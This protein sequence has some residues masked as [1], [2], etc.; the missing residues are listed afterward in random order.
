MFS[1]MDFV[2]GRGGGESGCLRTEN[3]NWPERGLGPPLFPFPVVIRP[4]VRA[5][6]LTTRERIDIDAYVST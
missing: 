2:E 4:I 1:H 3:G 6:A 5:D